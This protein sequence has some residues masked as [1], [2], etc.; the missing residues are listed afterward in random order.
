MGPRQDAIAHFISVDILNIDCG[1]RS[2]STQ[3]TDSRDLP[4]RYGN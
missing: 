2:G 4:L 1:L 3:E